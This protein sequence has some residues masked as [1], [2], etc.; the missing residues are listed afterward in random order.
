MSH[1]I[2]ERLPVEVWVDIFKH[3][4]PT[5]LLPNPLADFMTDIRLFSTGKPSVT[6]FVSSTMEKTRLSLVCR[7]FYAILSPAGD[8]LVTFDATKIAPTTCKLR[9]QN[10]EHARRLEVLGAGELPVLPESDP[11]DSSKENWPPQWLVQEWPTLQFLHVEA[12]QVPLAHLLDHTPRLV[13]L[14]CTFLDDASGNSSISAIL[15]HPVFNRLTHLSLCVSTTDALAPVAMPCLAFLRLEIVDPCYSAIYSSRMRAA[16]PLPLPVDLLPWTLPVLSSLVLSGWIG[17]DCFQSL[18]PFIIRQR[19]GLTRFHNSLVVYHGVGRIRHEFLMHF[20]NLKIYGVE[21]HSILRNGFFPV[22]S[23]PMAEEA[24]PLTVLVTGTSFP[25]MAYVSSTPLSAVAAIIERI[26]PPEAP[27]FIERVMLSETWAEVRT[28]LCDMK[29]TTPWMEQGLLE[30]FTQ[31]E[32]SGVEMVDRHGASIGST[33]KNAKIGE[34][35]QEM[36]PERASRS[37]TRPGRAG[38]HPVKR[39]KVWLE[40]AC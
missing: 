2:L 11:L 30:F 24:K 10:V 12:A 36:S 26:L 21:F 4:L 34:D 25:W 16:I 29:Q 38:W 33:H 9:G 18:R 3:L 6:S 27:Y 32:A 28:A 7:Y 5:E 20:P 40:Q 23:V 15:Q 35:R 17:H 19:E 8:R 22:D 13:A 37:P 1:N 39:Y 31:L 14:S